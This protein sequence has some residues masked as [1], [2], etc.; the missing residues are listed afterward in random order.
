MNRVASRLRALGMGAWTLALL[1]AGCRGRSARPAPESIAPLPALALAADTVR[2][3]TVAAGV[4]HHFF[5]IA[6]GPWAVHV[7]DVDRAACV[8]AVAAKGTDMDASWRAGA[9]GRARTS[10]IARAAAAAFGDTLVLAAVNADFFELATGVP[11]AAFV[12]VG[13]TV[14]GPNARP[15]FALVGERRRPWIG[16]MTTRGHIAVGPDTFPYSAI[17][18]ASPRGIAVFTRRWG[19]QTDTATGAVEVVVREEEGAADP[20]HDKIA[21]VDTL[22]AGVT[23][24]DSG[25]VLIAGRDAD[26]AL[27]RRLLALRPGPVKAD[28]SHQDE[29]SDVQEAVGGRPVLLRSGAEVGNLDSAGGASFAPVRHPRTA[30]GYDSTAR[31]LLFVT[32]DGRQPGYSEGMTLRELAWLMGELGAHDALNL[33]GGGSTAMVVRHRGDSAGL[34]LVNRPSDKEGE[35][36]VGNALVVIRTPSLWLPPLTGGAGRNRGSCPNL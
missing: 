27:R 16:R 23:I 17:N 22:P 34:R 32:V 24:P 30:V 33:D 2:A 35:R 1:G 36:T 7:L 26:S 5:Y 3:D 25:L 9:A 14:A 18:R 19:P 21:L 20:W 28:V 29:P 13:I 12:R 10:D 11:Q 31:R 6:R 8:T 15:V 4:V